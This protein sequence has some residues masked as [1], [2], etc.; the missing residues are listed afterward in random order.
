MTSPIN[1]TKSKL[2]FETINTHFLLNM[3]NTPIWE[4]VNKCPWIY[5]DTCCSH[6][7]GWVSHQFCSK[8]FC[9]H[10]LRTLGYVWYSDTI[11]S[12]TACLKIIRILSD[13]CQILSCYY[14]YCH[15]LSCHY[16]ST[17]MLLSDYYQILFGYDQAAWMYCQF[18]KHAKNWNFQKPNQTQTNFAK[19]RVC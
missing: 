8:I 17:I 2:E 14:Q 19:E 18:I 15:V 10:V 6:S 7:W 5:L 13:T 11:L 1:F 9:Y 16:Q 4:A 3:I 12:F